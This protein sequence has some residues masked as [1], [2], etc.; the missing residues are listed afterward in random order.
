MTRGT[1]TFL[2]LLT[3]S[4]SAWSQQGGNNG[5]NQNAA[6]IEINPSGVVRVI[7]PRKE[8][9]TSGRKRRE[10]FI[11]E[12][13]PP[14][15]VVTTERRVIS[16]KALEAE[17]AKSLEATGTVPPT[18]QS[19]CGIYRIDQIVLD[20]NR[21]DLYIVGP[22]EG[23]APDTI[24]RMVCA[25]S[26]RPPLHLDDLVVALRATRRRNS[27]M[28]CS[29]DPTKENMANLQ[30]YLRQNS[31]VTTPA[32]A[33]Q[34]YGVM[35]RVLGMQEVS[36]WGVPQESHFA[37]VLVEADLRM[38]RISL[39]IERP[40]VKG[41]RSQLS[42]LKPQG[43]SLQRWWFVPQY[44]PVNVDADHTVFQLSGPRVK[45]L[46]QEE[47]SDAAGNRFDAA[48][49][50]QSTE[51]FAQLFTEH[52][53]ELAEKELVFA[54][55]QNLFDLAVLGAIVN[56]EQLDERAE[57]L[58]DTFLNDER[59]PLNKYPVPQFVE[60]ASTNRRA[61]QFVIGLV[62]GVELHP[63][64]AIRMNVNEQL[65]APPSPRMSAGQVFV[66]AGE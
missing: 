27:S 19:L 63:E 4:T 17:V 56:R 61:G 54:E 35:A 37:S 44:D 31:T 10:D 49:T 52:Y 46:A 60:S 6:G 59:L 43:N 32:G 36:L 1:I 20:E 48:S 47:Y 14:D 64:P 41:I 25:E 18:L 53:A 29:I 50:R 22:A 28:G 9:V 33:A 57:W 13:L 38:K 2:L 30:N 39:G 58:A 62:G 7:V 45:L 51:V 11:S 65:H 40:G 26:G 5:Q 16:L 55:L 15:M 24:G 42:L 8:S 23:F 12:S 66:N 3:M 34:R 21:K